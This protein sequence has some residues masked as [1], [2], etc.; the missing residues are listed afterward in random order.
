MEGMVREMQKPL[1]KIDGVPGPVHNIASKLGADSSYTLLLV[2]RERPP[3][4]RP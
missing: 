1:T 2:N 4:I 3:L